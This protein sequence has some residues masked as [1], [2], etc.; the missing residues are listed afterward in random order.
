MSEP[1]ISLSSSPSVC[2]KFSQLV[3][4]LQSSNKNNF[5]QFFR[6]GVWVKRFELVV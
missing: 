6:H 5:A 3:E 2:H 4:I 1:H